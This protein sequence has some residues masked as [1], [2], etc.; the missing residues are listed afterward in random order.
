M[1]K[2]KNYDDYEWKS[3]YNAGTLA[4]L[5]SSE[6]EQYLH[7]HSMQDKVTVTKKEKVE[8]VKAHI[9][10]AA[11]DGLVSNVQEESGESSSDSEEFVIAVIEDTTD[12]TAAADDSTNDI[13]RVRGRRLR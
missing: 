12:I 1:N 5:Y 7:K 9:G 13:P 10:K 11:Y 3:M 4:K 6:L 2:A 8:W